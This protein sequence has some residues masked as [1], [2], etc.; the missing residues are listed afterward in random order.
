MFVF[1]AKQSVILG[2]EGF[3]TAAILFEVFENRLYAVQAVFC[4]EFVQPAGQVQ[5]VRRFCA[6]KLLFERIGSGGAKLDYKLARDIFLPNRSI[7]RGRH[8]GKQEKYSA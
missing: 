5:S 8:Y 4:V 3:E 7:G 6:S 2:V 1:F